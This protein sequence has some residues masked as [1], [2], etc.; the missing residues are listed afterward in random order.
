MPF[1]KFCKQKKTLV[2]NTQPILIFYRIVSN[3]EFTTS[4][5]ITQKP[6]VIISVWRSIH[7]WGRHFGLGCQN[8]IL[9]APFVLSLYDPKNEVSL[10]RRKGFQFTPNNPAKPLTM[11]NCTIRVDYPFYMCQIAFLSCSNVIMG[12]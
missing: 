9:R 3:F 4:S 1:Y 8:N 11:R 12:G 10:D 7:V 2:A 6:K 5:L